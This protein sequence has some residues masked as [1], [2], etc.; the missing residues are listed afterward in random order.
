M[1]LGLVELIEIRLSHAEK[2]A[3]RKEANKEGMSLS[4]WARLI[5]RSQCEQFTR[6]QEADK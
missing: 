2:I 6:R 3:F 4:A 1:S 5:L